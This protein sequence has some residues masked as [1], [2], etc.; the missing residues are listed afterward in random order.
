MHPNRVVQAVQTA[1]FVL[2]FEVWLPTGRLHFRLVNDLDFEAAKARVNGVQVVRRKLAFGENVVDIVIGRITLLL[3]QRQEFLDLFPKIDPRLG[4]D[5]RDDL[6]G[7]FAVRGGPSLPRE[8]R[9]RSFPGFAG[10]LGAAGVGF[11]KTSS[12]RH[13][14]T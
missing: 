3:G 4:S 10:R 1:L 8:D 9:F 11:L 12:V 7:L 2:L 6:Q 5:R 14:Q 13:G